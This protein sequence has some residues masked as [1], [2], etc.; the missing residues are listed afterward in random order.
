MTTVV[1]A[2]RVREHSMSTT[3]G[4]FKIDDDRAEIGGVRNH[5]VAKE[6][7]GFLNNN[8]DRCIVATRG[9]SGRPE[10]ALYAVRT[11]GRYAN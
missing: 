9:M 7:S 11:F 8:R 6:A 10:I 5:S 4:S 2:P 1:P 3:S